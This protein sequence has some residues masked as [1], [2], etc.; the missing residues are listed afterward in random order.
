MRRPQALALCALLLCGPGVAAGCGEDAP[1]AP[2]PVKA[3]SPLI[4]LTPVEYNN[5]I[6]DLLGLPADADQWPELP[7]AVQALLPEVPDRKGIFGSKVKKQ[8]AWPWS[9]NK[10]TG[11]DGYEGMAAGQVASSYRIEQLNKAAIHYAGYALVSPIFFACDA[12]AWLSMAAAERKTCALSSVRRFA[13]RAWRRPMSAAELER[14]IAFFDKNWAD[15]QPEAALM[16]TIAGVLQAPTFLF[17]PE[18]GDK[19]AAVGTAV[20]LNDWEMA[21][22]L[23]YFLCDTMPDSELFAAA[24]AGKLS[25]RAQVQAQ[26]ERLLKSDRARAAVVRFHNQWLGT[27]KVYGISPARRAY[28]PVF[29]V[30][31][32]PPLDTT[33]DAQWPALL[34][35]IRHSLKAETDRFIERIV[36]DDKGTLEALLTDNKGYVSSVTGPLYGVGDCPSGVPYPG[37]GPGK[38]GAACALDKG[39]VD[40]A[41]DKAI[42]VPFSLVAATYYDSSVTLHPAVFPADQRAGV[43]TLPSLLAVGAYPVHP[44]PI[45]RG[46]LVLGRLLC[47]DP[48]PPIPGAAA[49]APPDTPGAKSTNRERTAAAT[50]APVCDTCHK[51]INPAGFAFE[52]YDSFGRWRKQDNGKDVDATGTLPV[53]GE[54]AITF[55]DGVDLARKL[56]GRPRV[57]HCYTTHLVR[58]ATGV[59]VSASHAVLKELQKGFAAD[60]DI[61][62]LIV[63]ITASDLFRYRRSGGAK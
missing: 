43:L 38:G 46:L 49:A 54:D 55:T 51:R 59:E 2:Q 25:T 16:L 60:G 63:A 52:H 1:P 36:F 20:P 10:E 39:K 11:V 41:P 23:S 44:S 35:P 15:G 47:D 14:L 5:T 57:H 58:Y 28:G 17:R 19:G 13:Q 48:G 62:K 40:T 6:R 7:A 22:R 34:G 37:G 4:A 26:A 32:T 9:F 33:G 21:S 45:D 30:D 12:K 18:T 27:D 56:A 29:G 53:P 3:V 50:K 31:P 42:K 61:K 24:A 8:A